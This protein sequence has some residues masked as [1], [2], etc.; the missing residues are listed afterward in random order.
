MGEQLNLTPT[1]S[2]ARVRGKT[3]ANHLRFGYPLAAIRHNHRTQTTTSRLLSMVANFFHQ[4][5]LVT[6]AI[7]AGYAVSTPYHIP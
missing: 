3:R 2:A 6:T 5:V 7:V 1:S 4:L